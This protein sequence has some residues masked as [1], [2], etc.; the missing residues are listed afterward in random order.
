MHD[1][2]DDHDHDD[3]L[4][5]TAEQAH[6]IQLTLGAIAPMPLQATVKL[7]GRIELP[8]AGMS[9]AGTTLEGRINKIHVVP[10]Q[11]VRKGQTLFALENP[12][13][14]GWKQDLIAREADLQFLSRE[15]DRQEQLT[16][17]QIAP[18]KNYESVLSAH[19][20][21][22]AAVQALRARLAFYHLTAQP[23]DWSATFEIKAPAAG[24][25][26]HLTVHLGEFVPANTPLLHIV[27]NSH[28]HLHLLAF[29]AESTRLEKG[30]ALSF[31][32]QSRPETVLPARILWINALVNEADN[33]YD[34]HA[35]IEGEYRGLS[36]GEFVEARVI[37]HET[38]VQVLPTSAITTDKGLHYIFVLTEVKDDELHFDKVLVQTG[39][40][41]LGYTEVMP[42][43]PLP[44]VGDSVVV[45][46]GA[47]FLMAQSR[48][49]EGGHEHE[50]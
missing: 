23:N 44:A 32:V 28:L 46:Q 7:S 9:V 12:D 37:N 33:S 16:T 24:I 27:D 17:E 45:I 29:G 48:M 40:S 35:E 15:L 5:I 36:P 42:L 41:D 18:E 49:G 25:V 14:I 43:D 3:E 38:S 50:H 4:A 26:Q 31:F 10:G 13:I 19:Q 1:H 22:L 11:S 39:I 2:H 8:P 34:V 6:Y 20:S 30:Q 47:F 21:T